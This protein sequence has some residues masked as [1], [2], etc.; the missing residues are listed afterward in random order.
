MLVGATCTLDMTDSYGDGWVGAEWAAPGFGQS[1]SLANGKQGA[2]SFVV[3][4]PTFEVV[5]GSC[6]VKSDKCVY[7]DN[8][9]TDQMYSNNQDC[10]IKQNV[11]FQL[12]VRSFDVEKRGVRN[13]IA[14]A[15]DFLEVDGQRYCGTKGP[16]GRTPAAGSELVWHTNPHAT[17][18]GFKICTPDS[19]PPTISSAITC[20]GDTM[21][22]GE[23]SWSLNCTDGT[24]LSGRELYTSGSPLAVEVGATCTL[25][26]TDSYGDGWGAA[27]TTGA[28]WAAPGF[29]RRFSLANP[30]PGPWGSHPDPNQGTKSFVVQPRTSG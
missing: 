27:G 13:G 1:F 15:F 30:G 28:T 16:Q 20:S 9:G 25:D 10:V 19:P 29:G 5:S 8:F 11:Q 4:S 22:P 2:E 7:S 23:V 24:T 17:G 21:Y 14:C 26:M 3:E 6:T 12:D 18:A